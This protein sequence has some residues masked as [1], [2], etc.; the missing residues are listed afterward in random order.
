VHFF[1][2]RHDP[3]GVVVTT[4]NVTALIV[5]VGTVP[6]ILAGLALGAVVAVGVERLRAAFADRARIEW[7][8]CGD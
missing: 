1:V 4:R 5:A 8:G 2:H 6:A 7:E 3:C